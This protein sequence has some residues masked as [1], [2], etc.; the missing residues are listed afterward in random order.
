MNIL[1]E[2]IIEKNL[3]PALFLEELLNK[4]DSNI[5]ALFDFRKFFIVETDFDKIESY[6]SIGF[7]KKKIKRR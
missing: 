3:D 7:C 2:T 6:L 1:A 5:L 4:N